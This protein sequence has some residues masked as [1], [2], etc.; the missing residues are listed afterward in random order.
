MS[1][2]S[3][4]RVIGYIVFALVLM[5]GGFGLAK[6]TSDNPEPKTPY[7]SNNTAQNGTP[8]STVGV[9]STGPLSEH[10]SVVTMMERH[11]LSGGDTALR[12]ERPLWVREGGKNATLDVSIT[13][14]PYSGTPWRVVV[15][16]TGGAGDR[17][18][19]EV[20]AR[21]DSAQSPI[22]LHLRVG[23]E[24]GFY[25]VFAE[26]VPRRGDPAPEGADLLLMM[27]L[28]ENRASR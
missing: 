23:G 24:P 20:V 28:V 14:M 26:P 21:V 27:K 1:A 2:S 12:S 13:E 11:N 19:S 9:N 7:L 16:R 10:L 8:D 3:V 25:S 5:G 4:P 15:Y 22:N 18:P 17:N 6:V